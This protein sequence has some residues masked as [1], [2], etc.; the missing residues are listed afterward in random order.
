MSLQGALDGI[1]I[2]DLTRVLAGP[3]CTQLLGDLG[4]D[5][6]KIERPGAGDDTRKWGPPFLKDAG[7]KDT[8]ESAY[9]LSAN[10]NKRSVAIDMAKPEGQALIKRLLERCDVLAENFKQ[11]DLE[12]YGLDW[13]SLKDEFPRLIYCSITGFGQDGPYAPRAGYD[14]LAQGMS[15]IMS[16]TG[17]PEGQPM[18]VAVA[19]SDL[20]AGLHAAV[21]ILA[22]LRHRDRSGQGQQ[23]DLALLDCQIAGLSYQAEN[24]LI[25]GKPP[26]RLGNAHPTIVPYEVFPALDGHLILA[27][28]NDGQFKKFCEVADLAALA[29]DERYATNK[30]RILNRGTL[31]PL[32]REA[33][34]R[35]P[36]QFW[37][38]ELE[39]ASVPAGPVNRID[40]VFADP[41]VQHRRMVCEMAHPATDKKVPMVASPIKMSATPPSYRHPPPMLGQHT[42]EVLGESG[43]AG[44]EIAALRAKGILA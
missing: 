30:A 32:L 15:G 12:R 41:Q 39:K 44:D 9:Y 24:Y 17:E 36:L 37:L 43:L 8:T 2:L 19:V 16:I 22:A 42:D 31:I 6:I 29:Q 28:G 18:K 27:V 23:L 35:K 38:D 1:R 7:G 33:I 40:Q 25:S 14:Y 13:K 4:A 3:S 34:A 20:S 5:V 11:G 21:A 10:R 26:V